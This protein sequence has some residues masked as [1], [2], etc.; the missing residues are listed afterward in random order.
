MS[1]RSAKRSKYIEDSNEYVRQ[2]RRRRIIK[3]RSKGVDIMSLV[4][5]QQSRPQ[6]EQTTTGKLSAAAEAFLASLD[7]N[8]VT[9]TTTTTTTSATASSRVRP[10]SPEPAGLLRRLFPEIIMETSRIGRKMKHYVLQ[11]LQQACNNVG[12]DRGPQAVSP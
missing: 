6:Q 2:R 10:V 8:P 9:H 7:G 3:E 4:S 5:G 1:N 12:E 11:E